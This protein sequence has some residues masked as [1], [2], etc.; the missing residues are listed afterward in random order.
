MKAPPQ[1]RV[2]AAEDSLVQRAHLIRVLKADGDMSVVGQASDAREAVAAVIRLHP[3]V[4]TMDL[5]LPGDGVAAIERIMTE[6]PVPI[7]VLF[8]VSMTSDPAVQ[9]ALAAGAAAAEPKPQRWTAD[10][11]VRLRARVRGLGR[12]PRQ[13]SRPSASGPA[14]GNH[15]PHP[16]TVVALA[17]STGGPAAILRVLSGLADLRAPILLVQHIHDDFIGG[18]VSSTGRVSPLPVRA[19]RDGEP[20]LPGVVYV[21]PSGHHL[22]MDARRKVSLTSGPA[23]LHRPSA[24]ELFRSVAA[25]AGHRGIGVLLTGMGVDGARG[26]LELRRAG[27]HTIA[28]D[29]ASSVIYGMPAAAAKLN[30]AIEILPLEAIGAAVLRASGAFA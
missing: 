11:E 1:V 27:G 10:A 18:F 4:V 24:D 22:R 5:Q 19:A 14:S 23:G 9:R 2:V 28:Q 7:L 6:S 8:P 25:H 15:L 20:L 13:A 29:E 16:G 12:T 17:A 26:L 21:A 30:A 3:D